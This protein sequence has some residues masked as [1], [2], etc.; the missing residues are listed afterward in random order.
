MNE[1]ERFTVTE[2][3]VKLLRAANVGWGHCE[4]GA[5]VIDCERPYGNSDVLEDIF[6]ILAM[7]GRGAFDCSEAEI[8]R[9]HLLHLETETALQIFLCTGTMEPGTYE[10]PRYYRRWKRAAAGETSE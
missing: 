1:T 8:D 9:M 7:P 2:E 4:F 3:H 5:P 6:R 10:T